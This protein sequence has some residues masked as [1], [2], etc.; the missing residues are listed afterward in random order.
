MGDLAEPVATVEDVAHVYQVV[1]TT[2]QKEGFSLPKLMYN[3][4]VAPGRIPGKDI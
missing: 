1:G 3:N 2:L 4:E